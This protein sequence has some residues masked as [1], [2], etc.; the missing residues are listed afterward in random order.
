MSSFP[1][2]GLWD[3]RF[4]RTKR[5]LPTS[6]QLKEHHASTLHPQIPLAATVGLDRNLL[7]SDGSRTVD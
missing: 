4:I 2:A 6:R 5:T 3:I 7:D 1:F